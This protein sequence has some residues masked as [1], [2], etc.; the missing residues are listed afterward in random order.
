MFESVLN[1]HLFEVSIN[2]LL[3]ILK[4]SRRQSIIESLEKIAKFI[5]L[6]YIS[7][8]T[9]IQNLKKAAADLL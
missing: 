1:T 8:I 7:T 4:F 6:I 2:V 3:I 5:K 9:V